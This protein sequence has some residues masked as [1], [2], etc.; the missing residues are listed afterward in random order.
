MTKNALSLVL[1]LGFLVGGFAAEANAQ[2]ST[3]TLNRD[4]SRTLCGAYGCTTVPA[5]SV[6][7]ART[8]SVDRHWDRYASGYGRYDSSRGY[9]NYDLY[10][11]STSIL[12]RY[13]STYDTYRD[14]YRNNS[15][16]RGYDNYRGYDSFNRNSRLND[17]YDNNWTSS[18]HRHDNRRY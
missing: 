4:G 3:S 1:G 10:G 8:T 17:C 9:N 11:R 5:S 6:Y 15:S 18:H 2:F 7:N 12:P 14:D 16:Y 13:R